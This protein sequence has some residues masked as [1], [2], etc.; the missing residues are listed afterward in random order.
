[1]KRQIFTD[2]K[3]SITWDIYPGLDYMSGNNVQALARIEK[4]V[5]ELNTWNDES[6]AKYIVDDELFGDFI[7]S[8]IYEDYSD[9]KTCFALNSEHKPMGVAVL[10]PGYNNACII[11]YVV[12]ADKY[13]VKKAK[14]NLE[15][16]GLG[17]R[18]ISSIRDNV[19]EFM[20][21]NNNIEEIRG[22]IRRDNIPSN[23]A[24]IKAGFKAYRPARISELEHPSDY[25][26]Y[27]FRPHSKEHSI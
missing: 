14:V 4:Y 16:L 21:Y 20:G 6:I 2:K 11:E 24:I 27:Y 22:I 18:M 9:Y 25:T 5:Q 12:I 13:R 8:L 7:K 3:N 15:S 23:K 26:T 17:T 19:H 1:M 10:S